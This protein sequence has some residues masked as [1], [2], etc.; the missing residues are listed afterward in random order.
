MMMF[1]GNEDKVYILDKAEG[2]AEQVNGHPAW[3][4]V[5]DIA[6]HQVQTMDIMTNPFCSSGFHLPNGSFYTFG[7]NG[8]V[9]PGGNIG[10]VVPP[11]AGSASYDATYQDYNGGKSIRVLNPCKSS[12]NFADSSCQWYDDPSV[13]SMQK[14]RWYSTAEAL[15]DG[16]IV[17]IGG[18][19]NG[20][21]V[22][23]NFPNTDPTYEGGAAEPTYEFFPSRGTP[24]NMQFMTET[25]GLNA[26]PHAFLMPSGKMFV[27]AN[28]STILWDY[29]AN[30]E[31]PLPPMPKGIVRVYPAS[32]ATAMLPLTPD[33]N[34]T[35]TII[36][37][38]GSDMP[39]DAYGNYSFPAINTWDYPAS[40]DCQT[41]TPEPTDGSTAQYVQDDD[42]PNTG[43]TMG[44]F[45]ALPDG[46]MLVL[47]GGSNG[48]A[49]FAT[50]TGQSPS[51]EFMPHWQSLAAGP[52]GQPAI[53]DPKAPK[54]SRWSTDGLSTS[55]IARLYH[56]SAIVLPD[57]S[58]LVAG[59]NP[60]LDVNTTA[61]FP[62]EYRAEIFYPPYF[63]AT[64]RPVPTGV[65][66]TLSYG[67]SP[68]DISIP[69]SSYSGSSNDAADNTKVTL[70][71]SGFT[72]HA[73]NMGQRHLQLNNTYT[74]AS[75]GSITL[76]VSQLPPNANIFTPG[77]A[78]LF[79]VMNGIPSNGTMVIVGN[80]QVGTQPV[81][82]AS[83][84][85]ANV[86]VDSAKGS[87][88]QSSTT[89]GGN[90]T[91]SSGGSHTTTIIVA[92]V[93]GI[94]AIGILGALFGICV[95]R[96]RRAAARE[97][98]SAAYAMSSTG[99]G[100]LSGS[101]MMGRNSDSSAFVPLQQSN[102]S[103]AWNASTASLNS[104]GYAP[105]PYRDE[106]E[107]AAPPRGAPQPSMDYDP[108]SAPRMS[109]N[110]PRRW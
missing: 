65:P 58:V 6:T 10:S 4:A 29:T 72:T 54:G 108:Y 60:N 87:A 42:M 102:P 55:N 19:V 97:P 106:H 21:Y 12:Q 46:K 100:K 52:V 80:G 28:L 25:S 92:I 78:L 103:M 37:C 3:G 31:T 32:G 15:S 44:Q 35:P 30:T 56:S 34:Y 71:R 57:A 75:D 98:P 79:V 66:T 63:S 69:A 53:Y 27:Q 82:A 99:N 1:L 95:A 49:G 93:A 14:T 68:F 84:L 43:R 104:P 91:T 20:G 61:P 76:H 40:N 17:L 5:W 33:N 51:I 23:R 96:R 18:F 7:G 39:A 86:R 47:N 36:F 45:I 101:E 11:G 9:S 74:V 107:Y 62:T 109:T 89:N 26:Y 88:S 13:L 38:G 67:G 16:T 70:I 73:M 94:A 2:N 83:T 81:S 24:Q 64:T 41:I 8:A 48:T 22:N 50:A 110:E 77:P 105:S 90:N 59:S 85:P